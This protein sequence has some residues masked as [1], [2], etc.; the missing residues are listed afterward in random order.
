MTMPVFRGSQ[1]RLARRRFEHALDNSGDSVGVVVDWRAIARRWRTYP[2]AARGGCD[3]VDNQF[4][5]WAASG[6]SKKKFHA[7][8]QRKAPRFPDAF[9]CAFASSL[10]VFA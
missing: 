3:C 5:D 1:G 2:L 8:A 7:K 10:C 9:L 4:G 6:L